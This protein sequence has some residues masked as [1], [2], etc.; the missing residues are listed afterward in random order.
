MGFWDAVASTIYKQSAPHSRRITTPTP[1]HPIFTHRM[2]FLTLSQQ[3]KALKAW[4]IEKY[5]EYP[6][7]SLGDH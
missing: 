7:C 5:M 3:R 6:A 2:L 4:P 1:H